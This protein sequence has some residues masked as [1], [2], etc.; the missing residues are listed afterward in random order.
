MSKCYCSCENSRSKLIGKEPWHPSQRADKFHIITARN[1]QYHEPL[2]SWIIRSPIKGQK[3]ACRS[4]L[5]EW[6]RCWLKKMRYPQI[7]LVEWQISLNRWLVWV[8]LL[9]LRKQRCYGIEIR[10]RN[11]NN[12]Y[13]AKYIHNGIKYQ[14]ELLLLWRI[15]LVSFRNC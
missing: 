13:R 1:F 11:R 14:L 2:Y 7:T 8:Y 5:N 9:L 6:M 10:N 3:I 12:F 4:F 15:K